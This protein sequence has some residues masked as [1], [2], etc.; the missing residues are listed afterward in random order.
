KETV[1]W[2]RENPIRG[3]S[4]PAD[5]FSRVGSICAEYIHFAA[6]VASKL[7][8]VA[9][10]FCELQIEMAQENPLPFPPIFV[11][12]LFPRSELLFTLGSTGTLIS[13]SFPV[14]KFQTCSTLQP[15]CDFHSGNSASAT[16]LSG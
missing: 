5:S 15:A 6:I 14:S 1:G 4:D 10:V 8:S 9:K 12:A 3:S 16:S 7:V 13:R 2:A 11:Q